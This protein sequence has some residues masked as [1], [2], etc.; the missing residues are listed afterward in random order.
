MKYEEIL[1]VLG[2]CGLNCGKCIAFQGGAVEECSRRLKDLLGNNFFS[3]AERFAA[4]DPVFENYRNFEEL[5]GYFC[6][7]Q[8]GGCREQGCLFRE[9]KV[10]D[11]IKE[12]GVD[13]CFQCQQFPC[14]KHGFPEGLRKRW[15]ENNL[16][17][18]DIGVGKFYERT[19][20]KP[21]YP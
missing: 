10:K 12:Q 21:R 5:L 9:C 6:R 3:Y 4:M 18:K 13:F 7:G 16:L 17:M 11:C 8:C 15:V 14:E 20:D 2:P 1:K 19:R